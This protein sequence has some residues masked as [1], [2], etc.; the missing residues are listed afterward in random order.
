MMRGWKTWVAALGAIALGIYEIFNGQAEAGVG[1]IVFGGGLIG[2]G[3]KIEKK[4][5]NG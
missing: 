2:L 1:H 4:P 3:H 5:A